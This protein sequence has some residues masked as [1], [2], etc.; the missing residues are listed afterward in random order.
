MQVRRRFSVPANLLI[1]GEYLVTRNGGRGLS[2]AVDPRAVCEVEP[3]GNGRLELLAVTGTGRETIFPEDDPGIAGEVLSG[4]GAY[5]GLPVPVGR[6]TVDTSAF[7]DPH[8]GAKLGL[9]SSA[10]ATVLM[11][12]AFL[13]LHG[14]DPTRRIDPLIRLAIEAHR[15]AH[16]GRGSGYDIATSALGGWVSFTGGSEPAW[17]ASPLDAVARDHGV[18]L[19]GWNHARP[20]ASAGAVGRFDEYLGCD[21]EATASLML[22]NNAIVAELE[23]AGEWREM[24]TGVEAARLFGEEIGAAIGV[25]AELNLPTY[26]PDDGWIAKASGAGNERALAL[27]LPY[28]RRRLPRGAGRLRIAPEGLRR[29][30]EPAG[31]RSVALP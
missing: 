23:A 11:T 17:H 14:L 20:V 12:A 18:V 25:S 30:P 8:T 29:E 3:G 9:G 6:I 7:F 15:R 19:Y 10:A 27:S 2:V 13:E 26:H 24:F 5:T 28:P 22:R 31:L 1:A 4:V 16:G 21:Q